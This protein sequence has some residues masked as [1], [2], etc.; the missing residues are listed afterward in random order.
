[1]LVPEWNIALIAASIAISLLGAF[2]STQLMCQA[3]T[4]RHFAGVLV[5]TAL[6]SL[7]FGFC[8]IWSLHEVAMLAYGLDL[9]IGID[10]RLTV[11]SAILAV[12]FT[13]IALASDMLWDRYSRGRRQGE[14]RSTRKRKS[15][16]L[17][18]LD[19]RIAPFAEESAE[20]LLPP[21]LSTN[22][23]NY[24]DDPDLERGDPSSSVEPHNR[25]P[26]AML[27]DS[28]RTDVL[29]SQPTDSF[30]SNRTVF[31]ERPALNAMQH[32]DSNVSTG[33]Q[34]TSDGD[35][36]AESYEDTA[37]E[38][39]SP[40]RSSSFGASTNSALGLSRIMSVKRFRGSTETSANPFAAIYWTL[41]A[42]LN[43]A[44]IMKGFI[45]AIAITSMHYVGIRGLEVPEGHVALN[46]YLVIASFVICWIVC[47]VGCILIL[48]IETHLG[49]QLLF[50]MVATTGVA[51]MHFTGMRAATFYS[52][53][54]PTSDRGYPPGLATG[55]AAVAI[56]TC[57][58]A[59][60]LLAH[61]AT[62]SRNKLA[63]IVWTRRKLWMAIAQKETAESAAAARS[64]FI[65]SASHEI[66]TPLHHLQ[67][68]SDLLSRTEL[69]EEGRLLLYAI[70]RAT[71]TL[72]LITN[73]VLDWSRLEKDGEA[74][75]R[76]VSLDLRTICE[77]IITLLPNQD[78]DADVEVMVVVSPNVPHSLFIDETYVHRILMNL[79][80]NALK[81]TSS[82]Y[83][84]LSIEMNND[85]LVALCDR[86]WMRHTPYIPAAAL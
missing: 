70:Q 33:S 67:G 68:Y 35:A 6:G 85:D 51:A 73:N 17:E 55:V 59:N 78:E 64:E 58:A 12:V 46:A 38:S 52:Y 28:T 54:Q 74:T 30:Q 60:L 84:L 53:A 18:H 83:I 14:S 86:H 15:A 34:V 11:L 62:V 5:W 39:R 71:K 80:S 36:D 41:I 20:P 56:A 63:E 72:S 79:L 26:L 77:S 66:R 29:Q 31:T 76:P 32:R 22:S 48:E 2:T 45:W 3:K 7:T 40:R 37:T 25:P 82:G 44:T 47:V 27:Q 61:S 24:S 49:Q 1:M 19:G 81:F 9:R 23:E 4:S 21:S 42:G 10:V 8:S 43:V 16:Q 50:S 57:L 69:T 65:A 13:F 75:C